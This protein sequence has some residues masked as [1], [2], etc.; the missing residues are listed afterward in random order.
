LLQLGRNENK[1]GDTVR[2][3]LEAQR[4]KSLQLLGKYGLEKRDVLYL[5]RST[6]SGKSRL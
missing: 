5:G 2:E 3:K 1:R 4:K 6:G